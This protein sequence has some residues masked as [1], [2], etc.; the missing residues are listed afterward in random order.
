MY[1]IIQ[2]S[3][4]HGVVGG[5]LCT[6][7]GA[8]KDQLSALSG[9]SLLSVEL[10][11]HGVCVLDEVRLQP[12]F[13]SG[14]RFVLEVVKQQPPP[15]GVADKVVE[16]RV[17]LLMR[18]MQVGAVIQQRLYGA[19]HGVCRHAE[20][21][22]LAG[23]GAQNAE[24]EFPIDV[25]V[26]MDALTTVLDELDLGRDEG[27]ARGDLESQLDELMAVDGVRRTNEVAEVIEHVVVVKE[28]DI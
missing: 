21:P 22:G 12:G 7:V 8:V 2:V 16:L 26:G 3:K 15:G 14:M 28:A 20:C 5:D 4:E 24:T 6:L 13:G 23:P 17:V 1:G 18:L 11:D 9:H 10:A 25:E 27:I 19:E